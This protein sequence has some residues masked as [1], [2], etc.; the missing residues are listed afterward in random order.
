MSR[1]PLSKTTKNIYYR[2]P[3]FLSTTGER[4]LGMSMTE[5]AIRPGLTQPAMSAAAR[6]GEEIAKQNGY[7]LFDNRNL[8]EQTDKTASTGLWNG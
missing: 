1:C 8:L 3:S 2:K 4:D 7:S 5:M 6:R